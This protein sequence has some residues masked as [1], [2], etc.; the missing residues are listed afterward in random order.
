MLVATA[1]CADRGAAALSSTAV[2]RAH[3]EPARASLSL[4][5]RIIRGLSRTLGQAGDVVLARQEV[6]AGR[7]APRGPTPLAA[8]S[9]GAPHLPVSPFQFRLPPPTLA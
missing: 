1:L 7:S 5:A 3:A 4:A 6:R 9:P 2:P 8:Q